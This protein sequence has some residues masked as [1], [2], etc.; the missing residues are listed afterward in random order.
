MNASDI[1]AKIIENQAARK[2][3]N[4]R[5]DYRSLIIR[6]THKSGHGDDK[7][8]SIKSATGSSDSHRQSPSKL[9]EPQVHET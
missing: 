6:H 9:C 2:L 7:I 8:I 3:S 4:A 5:F 1:M